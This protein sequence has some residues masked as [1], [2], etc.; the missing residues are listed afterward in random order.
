MAQSIRNRF[1]PI[2]DPINNREGALYRLSVSDEINNILF[3][4]QRIGLIS[5]IFCYLDNDTNSYFIVSGYKRYWAMKKIGF[6][7]I[8]FNKISAFTINDIEPV[9]LLLFR[10]FEDKGHRVFN[11]I[12]KA[13]MIKQFKKL[14]VSDEVL[15]SFLVPYIDITPTEENLK[16]YEM[17]ADVPKLFLEALIKNEVSIKQLLSIVTLNKNNWNTA[18]NIAKNTKL[19]NKEFLR[20]LKLIKQLSEKREILFEDI[21]KEYSIDLILKNEELNNRIRG[22]KITNKL[23]FARYPALIAH[24]KKFNQLIKNLKIPNEISFNPPEN[25]EGSFLSVILKCRKYNDFKHFI[26]LL[27]DER[28]QEIIKELF[29]FF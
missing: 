18:F 1:I 7:K 26:D 15:M 9:L 29:E 6:K 11:D 24:E 19:N 17:L 22:K 10:I 27:T 3:S 16:N 28:K 13:F 23:L 20:V 14:N 12:E 2:N 8:G 4:I 21:I 5:P 25:F